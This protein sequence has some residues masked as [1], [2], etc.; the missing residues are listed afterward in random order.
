[1][2][3]YL[4]LGSCTAVIWLWLGDRMPQMA[5]SLKMFCPSCGGKIQFASQNL[6][7]KIPCPLCRKTLT[8]RAP[9]NLKMF[10]FFCKE[11][12][13]FPAHA[14]GRKISCPHCKMDITLKEQA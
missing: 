5:A 8:L 10:C 1:M 13:E 6:G 9:E 3:F 4:L 7:R 14:L 2:A 11:H 12:I